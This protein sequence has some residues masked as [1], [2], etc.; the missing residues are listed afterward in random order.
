MGKCVC[1][2][3]GDSFLAG[4]H[5][6]VVVSRM[7]CN[8]EGKFSFV[9]VFVVFVNIRW[10]QCGNLNKQCISGDTYVRDIQ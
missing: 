6:R 3:F 2:P 1:N 9:F 5:M 7:Q 4:I 8:G 10:F